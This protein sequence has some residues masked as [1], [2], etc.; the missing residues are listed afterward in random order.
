MTL[1]VNVVANPRLR[2]KRMAKNSSTT[3]WTSFLFLAFVAAVYIVCPQYLIQHYDGKYWF[4]LLHNVAT[5]NDEGPLKVSASHLFG[6][7]GILPPVV[8]KFIPPLWP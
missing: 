2:I 8:P 7:S 4:S 3:L 6:M 5:W 1:G